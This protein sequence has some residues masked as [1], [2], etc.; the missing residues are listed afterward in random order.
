MHA[1]V[2]YHTAMYKEIQ[3]VRITKGENNY[4]NNSIQFKKNKTYTYIITIIFKVTIILLYPRH[5]LVQ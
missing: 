3:T 2:G 1:D 5:F 4:Y